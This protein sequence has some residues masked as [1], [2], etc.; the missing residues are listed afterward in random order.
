MDRAGVMRLFTGS[1][2]FNLPAPQQQAA[3]KAALPAGLFPRVHAHAPVLVE[4]WERNGSH[5]L[6]LVNYAPQR[7]SIRVDFAHAQPRQVISPDHE[8]IL[9]PESTSIKL[10]LDIYSII[11]SPT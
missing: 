6:H 11:V 2:L 5:E 7:Q 3:L 4:N 10:D 1:P 8:D 9:L